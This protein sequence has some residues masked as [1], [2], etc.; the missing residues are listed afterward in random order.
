MSADV[1]VGFDEWLFLAGGT[2]EV[3]RFY[4]E[5]DFFDA[6]CLG[7]VEQLRL[8]E[9]NARERGIL[10][11]H[12]IVPDKLT[13]YS[14]FYRDDLAHP[15]N[16]PSQKV[17]LFLAEQP[18]AARLTPLLVDVRD[19][20]MLAKATSPKLYW[21]T[22]AHWTFEGCWV[23]F[24]ALCQNIG[25]RVDPAILDAPELAGDLFLDLGAK[26]DP[27][28]AET[29]VSKLFSKGAER[30]Y[31]NSLVQYKERE[32]AHDA[33]GLHV[34]S[35]IVLRNTTT[36]TDPRTVILFGDSY[37]EYRM[38]QFTGLLAET[39]ANTHF[40]WNN[41][42]DWDYVDRVKPDVVVTELAERFH[43]MVP[44]DDLRIDQFS[45]DRLDQYLSTFKP[46]VA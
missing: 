18:D 20:M 37:S 25:A 30:A 10:Y 26:L 12:L 19:A 15:Q 9:A 17:R 7:W 24:L 11:R 23:A 21:K 13:I 35:H 22:D 1:H 3:L 2:N 36:A 39:F 4:N 45:R 31:T 33:P 40:I 29:Y 5:G 32:N 14:E 42:I 28:V 46:V 16:A 38:H 43:T 34:G 27:P 8:R 6:A 44:T 41:S